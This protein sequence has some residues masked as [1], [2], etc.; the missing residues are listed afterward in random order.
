MT[1][2]HHTKPTIVN[3]DA[4]S[5]KVNASVNNALTRAAL[6]IGETSSEMCKESYNHLGRN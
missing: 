5:C 6:R 3:D 1:Q 2:P 4:V